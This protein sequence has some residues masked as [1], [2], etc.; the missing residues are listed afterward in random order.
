MA[1]Q[2]FFFLNLPMDLFRNLFNYLNIN[3]L[4]ILNKAFLKNK[5]LLFLYNLSLEHFILSEEIDSDE[6]EIIHW[7]IDHHLL[8]KSL[9]FAQTA[10]INHIEII[11]I[12]Q[13]TLT[14]LDFTPWSYK[15]DDTITK[16]NLEQ[17]GYCPSLTHLILS[18]CRHI[19]T[20][21][22]RNFLIHNPQLE[23]LDI[24]CT[25]CLSSK[26]IPF[27]VQYCPNLQYLY[28]D[29]CWWV[30]DETIFQLI[31][32]PDGPAAAAADG[33][34]NCCNLKNLRVLALWGRGIAHERTR[35]YQEETI[36]LILNSFPHLN[37]FSSPLSSH[38]E[39]LRLLIFRQVILRSICDPKSL[40]NSRSKSVSNDQE[41][42]HW[43][44]KCLSLRGSGDYLF[45]QFLSLP[46]PPLFL[47]T[48]SASLIPFASL[49]D[50]LPLSLLL[51]LLFPSQTMPW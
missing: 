4:M 19:E 37:Y 47:L 51:S 18:S 42:Q 11:K 27:L 16:Q 50:S 8:I 1:T 33:H 49:T 25:R 35:I 39:D 14:S 32:C 10:I 34:D 6:T 21:T 9:I 38:S 23:S 12:S 22:L 48:V 13:L 2:F 45:G 36:H 24:S 7:I 31:G 46:L 29:G 43:G 28:L 15:S 41:S 3:D 17:I 40:S 20:D 26:L 44:I 30:T 5:E